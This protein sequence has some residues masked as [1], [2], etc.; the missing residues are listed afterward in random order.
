[1]GNK[2][3]AIASALTFLDANGVYQT[4]DQD[5]LYQAMIDIA[6]HRL[7]KAGLARIFRRL[8]GK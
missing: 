7:D 1:D 4:P 8:A 2:R 6:N 5:E 3:T